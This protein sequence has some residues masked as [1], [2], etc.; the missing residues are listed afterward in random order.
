MCGHKGNLEQARNN[1]QRALKIQLE[2]LGNS[3]VD[4]AYSFNALGA[5][6][7]EEGYLESSGV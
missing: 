3:H 1:D 2:Q 6:C 4:V 5:V 7:F